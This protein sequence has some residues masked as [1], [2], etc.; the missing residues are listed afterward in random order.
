MCIE[1]I[2][3]LIC[4]GHQRGSVAGGGLGAAAPVCGDAVVGWIAGEQQR[5]EAPAFPVSD[6]RDCVRAGLQLVG[7]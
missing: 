6:R 4:G 7:E 2:K 3:V 1:V 5:G